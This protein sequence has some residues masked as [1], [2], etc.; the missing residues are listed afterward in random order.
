MRR[1]AKAR[2]AGFTLIAVM[3]AVGLMTVGALAIMAM[4][5]ASTRGN[6][7]ARQI[8]TA[9]ELTSRW[10]ERLRR[11][12]LA[13]NSTNTGTSFLGNTTYLSELGTSPTSGWFRPTWDGRIGAGFDWTGLPTNVDDQMQYCTLLQLTWVRS[14]ALMRADVITWWHRSGPANDSSVAN[15]ALYPKCGDGVV[16]NV[17]TDLASSTSVLHSVRASTLLRWTPRVAGGTP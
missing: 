10:M 14:G 5:E 12:A 11:D 17:L 13:W 7:E 1:P 15:R 3:V 16:E 6:V 9:T 8:G 4:Q 2:R